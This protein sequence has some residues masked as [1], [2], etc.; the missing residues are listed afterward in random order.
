MHGLIGECAGAGD[1]AYRAFLVNVAGHDA[2]FGFAGRDDAG[3]V[4]ADEARLRVFE[5]A[6]T[7]IMSRVGMPSVMATING[8]PASSASRIASAAKGGGTKIMV[9]L[10]PVAATASATVLKTGQPHA[11]CR[12]CQ[13]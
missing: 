6:H 12:P 8:T 3:A 5:L 1:D 4:G 13:A 2:D 10:A 11:L 7:L 9:A